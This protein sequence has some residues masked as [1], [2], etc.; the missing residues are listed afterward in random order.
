M[1]KKV[2]QDTFPDHVVGNPGIGPRGRNRASDLSFCS[3]W[4]WI[5]EISSE[6]A[7]NEPLVETSSRPNTP[8][9][10]C[11]GEPRLCDPRNS[12]LCA[13]SV[14][15]GTIVQ[16][17]NVLLKQTAIGFNDLIE[18]QIREGFEEIVEIASVCF[19]GLPSFLQACLR[20]EEVAGESVCGDT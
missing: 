13:C 20:G 3:P 1:F 7:I 15:G 2:S 4:D 6:P 19:K 18:G 16:A 11:K 10:G 8:S 14:F 5:D 17:I 12:G 9:D